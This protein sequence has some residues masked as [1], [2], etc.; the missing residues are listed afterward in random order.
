[1]VIATEIESLVEGLFKEED[2]FEHVIIIYH[3]QTDNK[4]FQECAVDGELQYKKMLE[5]APVCYSQIFKYTRAF[6]AIL[7]FIPVGL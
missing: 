7:Q 5:T 3:A 2:S 6:D 4:K 1:M